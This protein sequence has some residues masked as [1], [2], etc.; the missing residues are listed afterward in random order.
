[1]S[2]KIGDQV[3]K[4]QVLASLDSENALGSVNQAEGA[5]ASAQNAYDKLVN[6]SSNTDIQIAKVALNNAKSNYDNTVAGQKVLVSNALTT[7]HNAGLVAIPNTNTTNTIISPI[8]SGT[9]SNNEEG[10]YTITVSSVGNS[11]YYSL[12]GLETETNNIST[13]ATPMGTRGLFIQFPNNFSTNVNNIWTVSIPNTQAPGYLASYNAYQLALQ[14]Q[15]QA[16]TIA[17]GTVDSAQANLDQKVAGARSE[18][19]A[20]AKAQV[21]STNGA[22]QVAQG[23]YNNTVITAPTDGTITNVSISPGQIAIPNTP[24]IELLSN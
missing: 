11:Y 21:E 14:N 13:I 1:M 15:T 22:L 23:M 6:G 2:V 19:L 7:L 5:Y 18:D 24:I 10:I 4:G 8:I 16:I 12:S 9:Y 3:K 17:Q 20:M